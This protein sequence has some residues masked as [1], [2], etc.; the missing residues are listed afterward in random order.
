ML[1]Q[2]GAQLA[3]LI[4]RNGCWCGSIR[5]LGD[6]SRR[7]PD[8]R[9]A[10]RVNCRPPVEIHDFD[11]YFLRWTCR[12]LG[13]IPPR[14]AKDFPAVIAV[15]AGRDA[16][17]LAV[18]VDNQMVATVISARARAGRALGQEGT[19]LALPE[20]FQLVPV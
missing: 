13:S 9:G 8:Y 17:E 4:R 2:E 6:R 7:R 19:V 3:P 20:V 10:P 18:G 14:K 16:A 1:R 12:S 5:K 11:R 15:L